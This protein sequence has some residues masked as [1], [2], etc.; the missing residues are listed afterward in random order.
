[1]RKNQTI[2]K[3]TENLPPSAL[4]FTI[5]G[6]TATTAYTIEVTARTR[7]GPGPSRS[8]D[9]SSGVPPVTPDPPSHLALSNIQA[10]TVLLQFE[11]GFS[12]HTSIARW[13]VQAQSDPSSDWVQIHEV[14]APLATSLT[15]QG[16]KPYS[17]YRLRLVAEN[18][19]GQSD[20]S[21]PTRWF[22]TLQAP[23]DRPPTDVSVRALNETAVRVRWTVSGLRL[24]PALLVLTLLPSPVAPGRL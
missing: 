2:T 14:S 19:A 22:E 6:L 23:P 8:A 21:Q 16:L 10:R 20:P 1:M 4:N 12:G 11:P 17:N 15:V 24:L 5:Q 18:V 13:I 7:V 9:I 3:V